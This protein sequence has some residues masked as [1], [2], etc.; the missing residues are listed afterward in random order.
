[1]LAT[2]TGNCAVTNVTYNE[3]KYYVVAWTFYLDAVAPTPVTTSD[4]SY[5]SHC[6]LF[7]Q[8]C[9]VKVRQVLWLKLLL[10]P[11]LDL[12][13]RK[14][15][16]AKVMDLRNMVLWSIRFVANRYRISPH[17]ISLCPLLAVCL[18]VFWALI[19]KKQMWNFMKNVGH[20]FCQ[21]LIVAFLVGL[22]ANN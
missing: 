15:T 4:R 8:R 22:P 14:C 20:V 21:I 3:N 13:P 2:A 16:Y 5:V 6:L 1:M 19:K 17:L 7:P 11:T 12:L 9:S 10:K 18:F